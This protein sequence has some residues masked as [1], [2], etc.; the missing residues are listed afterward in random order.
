M[1]MKRALRHLFATHWGTRR[2]FTPQV[3]ADIQKAIAQVESQHPGALRFAVETALHPAELWHDMS[4][5]Q[6]AVQVFAHLLV[7]DT[8]HNNGVLI[9]VLLADRAVE[10][11]A[12]RGLAAHIAQS[13]WDQICRAMERHYRASDFGRGSVAGIEQIGRLLER[14]FPGSHGSSTPELPNQPVLL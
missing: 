8:H 7:W 2:R 14:H 11:L 12:D 9:Y 3:L 13:E 4:P 1:R 10:I 5:R 6:R